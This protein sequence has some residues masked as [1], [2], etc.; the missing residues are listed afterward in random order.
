MLFHRARL[1]PL[2]GQQPVYQRAQALEALYQNEGV[3][4]KR[5]RIKVNPPLHEGKWAVIH[6]HVRPVAT[7]RLKVISKG[8]GELAGSDRISFQL[9]KLQR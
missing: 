3:S 6:S 9:L 1:F 7:H 2:R 8:C 5:I 4:F